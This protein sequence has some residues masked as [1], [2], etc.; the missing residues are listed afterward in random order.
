M[1][2]EGGGSVDD[3]EDRP[4]VALTA[5]SA[6]F[7]ARAATARSAPAGSSALDA[8]RIEQPARQVARL[9]RDRS[10]PRPR[11]AA[12]AERLEARGRPPRAVRGCARTR[13]ARAGR[14]GRRRCRARRARAGG[15]RCRR[16]RARSGASR[17]RRRGRVG[18]RART[19]WR[20]PACPRSGPSRRAPL[21][22]TSRRERS[23]ASLG[24]AVLLDDEPFGKAPDADRELRLAGRGRVGRRRV[25]RR[26]R[27]RRSAAGACG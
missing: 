3:L 13:S 17:D 6:W 12:G 27:H 21:R 8:V 11:A 25:E 18:R 14:P 24:P 5:C 2:G 9:V 26:V 22:C 19:G 10:E 4:T 20:R 16:A 1:N 15:C 23:P 7:P